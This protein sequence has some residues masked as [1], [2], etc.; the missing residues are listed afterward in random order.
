VKLRN[1]Q[2]FA[3]WE[4]LKWLIVLMK[5]HIP[6]PDSKL[7]SILQ[8]VLGGNA[9]TS[10]I[11]T[12]APKEVCSYLH[13]LHWSKTYSIKLFCTYPTLTGIASSKMLIQIHM[14]ETRG[15]VQSTSRTRCVSDRTQV[16]KLLCCNM[17]LNFL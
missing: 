13:V 7:T 10:F 6:Y 9:K 2:V 11:C 5:G 14:E 12:A 4:V 1:I 16:S 15:T 17:S 3:L 8:S